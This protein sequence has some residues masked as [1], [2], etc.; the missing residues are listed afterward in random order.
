M[1]VIDDVWVYRGCSMEAVR[2]TAA[3]SFVW[4]LDE[5]EVV[6]KV[7]RISC[8]IRIIVFSKLESNESRKADRGRASRNTTKTSDVVT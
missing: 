4:C 6:R 7:Q 5:C 1:A 3:G 8:Q 2:D